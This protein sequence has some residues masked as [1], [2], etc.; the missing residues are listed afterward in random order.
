MK[1]L[2]LEQSY[3]RHGI[4]GVLIAVWLSAFLIIIAPF[5]TADLSFTIRLMI[6]PFYGVITLLLYLLIIPLQNWVFQLSQKWTIL[7]ESLFLAFYQ[8]IALLGSFAYYQTS[9]INGTYSF[10]KFTLEVYYPIFFVLL[11]VI[12]F[13]RWFLF[14]KSVLPSAPSESEK[15]TLR[16]TNKL[17]I[18]H[19]SPSDLI[20]VSSADNYVE[21]HYLKEGSLE[22]KLLR[23][24]LKNIYQEVDILIRVHRA[25]LINPKHLVEWKDATTLSLTQTEVPVSKTYKAAVLAL[26]IHP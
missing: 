16:G 23:T 21:V 19:L 12:V 18:L 22:K 7:H 15:I 20:C 25:H 8:F 13:A 3:K 9:I 1:T 5:D 4:I 11:S 26:D 17:D 2:Q 24:T 6:L 10:Q 14:K